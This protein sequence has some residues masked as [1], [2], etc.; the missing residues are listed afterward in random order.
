MAEKPKATPAQVD[1]KAL[2]FDFEH[3]ADLLFEHLEPLIQSAFDAVDDTLFDYANNARNNNEQNRYFE[4]M[5][6]LRLKRKLIISQVCKHVKARF[7]PAA[8]KEPP[9]TKTT[10]PLS[11]ESSNLA[12]SSELAE[13][14][15]LD[16]MFSKTSS[17][18]ESISLTLTPRLASA[19]KVNEQNFNNPLSVKHIIEDIFDA[20]KQLDIEL[21][22]RLLFYKHIDK[23]T[24]KH[25]DG[26]YEVLNSQLLTQG[27]LPQISESS[28]RAAHKGRHK[29]E[30]SSQHRVNVSNAKKS[31]Q[32]KKHFERTSANTEQ[33]LHALDL[34]QPLSANQQIENLAQHIQH[35]LNT[36]HNTKLDSKDLDV[37]NLVGM[38]F[39]YIL[40]DDNLA[41]EMQALI[42]RLQIPTLKVVL[43]NP[44][45]FK[46]HN[47][48]ART[49]LDRLAGAAIGWTEDCDDQAKESLYRSLKLIINQICEAKT[50]FVT[51]FEHANEQLDALLSGAERRRALLEQ[52]TKLS[53]E[54]RIKSRV[55]KQF[56]DSTLL[57][58]TQNQNT[59]PESIQ[60]LLNGPWKQVMFLAFLKDANE[61]NWESIRRLTEILIECAQPHHSESDRQKWVSTVPRLL[62]TIAIEL[63]NL[64]YSEN[65]V[66][67]SIEQIRKDLAVAFRDGALS[68]QSTQQSIFRANKDKRRS[69][70]NSAIK[71]QA[72]AHLTEQNDTQKL[73]NEGAWIELKD[74]KHTKKRYKLISYIS[75]AKVYVFVDRIGLH[76]IELSQRQLE[77][78]ITRGAVKVLEKGALVDRA[79]SHIISNLQR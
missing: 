77:Q 6:E 59:L 28:V 55:A 53:E 36:Q 37:I 39:E 19:Y 66:N 21:G 4:A 52:R 67:A 31:A 47:H 30:Q 32:T 29:E 20:S 7:R 18:L 51:K 10:Q 22:E 2:D 49:F 16:T 71:E 61:H 56:V 68:N 5:R 12:E 25:L 78:D 72:N 3:L 41:P 50:D 14:L 9:P 57:S 8:V 33:L 27:I 34:A 43:K 42:G 45:F 73:I 13:Q 40:G 76:P 64:A 17:H 38:L 1:H 46:S 23:H 63:Q 65:Q 58:L 11:F 26:V 62:K 44:H 75:E 79:L 15:A 24:L 70:G 60:T 54:G 74:H 35:V 69:N 48:P